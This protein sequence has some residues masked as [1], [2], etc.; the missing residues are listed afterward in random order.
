MAPNFLAPR[1]AIE[2]LQLFKLLFRELELR[3]KPARLAL[4]ND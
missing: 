2:R 1:V 3:F 4:T